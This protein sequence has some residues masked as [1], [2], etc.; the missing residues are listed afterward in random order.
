[1][2]AVRIFQCIVILALEQVMAKDFEKLGYI[3]EYD[4]LD[5]QWFLL[6]QRRNRV[7]ATMDLNSGQNSIGY[8][9]NMKNTVRSLASDVLFPFSSCFD[10][11][12]PPDKLNSLQQKKLNEAIEMHELEHCSGNAF[13]DGGTSSS[14]KAEAAVGVCTCIRPTHSIFS[15]KLRRF[16]RPCEM[17]TGQGLFKEDFA[18]PEAVERLWEN[19]KNTQDMAGWIDGTSG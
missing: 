10:E 14:R 2:L 5:A 9:T 18:N 16:V 3:M 4:I 12:L 19:D 7:W 15:Q 13:C 6:R 1:M 17:W 8:K 11:S